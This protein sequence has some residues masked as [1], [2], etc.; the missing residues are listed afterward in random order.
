MTGDMHL[1]YQEDFFLETRDFLAFPLPSLS[2]FL[3]L[4]FFLSL[5]LSVFLVC[6]AYFSSSLLRIESLLLALL[7]GDVAVA[8]WIRAHYRVSLNV[9]QPVE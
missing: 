5:S 1:E 8:K 4:S 3:F 7:D 9:A 2:F 6:R